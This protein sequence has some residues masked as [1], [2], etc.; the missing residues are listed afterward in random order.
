MAT[1]IW[2][3]KEGRWVLRVMKNG[4]AHKYTSKEPGIKGKKIVLAKSRASDIGINYNVTVGK[5]YER[6]LEDIRLRSSS[7][8][9]R[10]YEQYGRCYILPT[11]SKRKLVSVTANEWQN[12]LNTVRGMNGKPLAK[13]TLSNVRAIIVSFLL[14]A[15]R[16]GLE[17]PSN[18]RLQVPKNAPTKKKEILQPEH[19][20]R[21]FDDTETFI[22]EWY[23]YLFRFSVLTGLR[24]G[25]A[26]GLKW[27][28]L[29]GNVLTINRSVNY[30]NQIT[31][32][33][34][35]NARRTFA[36]GDLALTVLNEQANRTSGIK[37]DWV[38]CRPSGEM[39]VQSTTSQAWDRISAAL[40]VKTSPYSLRH[41]FISMVRNTIP[42]TVIKDVVGHSASMDTFGVY[43]HEVTDDKKREAEL[44]NLTLLKRLS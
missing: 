27:S 12:I 39:S 19:L 35:D 16:D 37:S 30:R 6:F 10:S 40:G 21:L 28:D 18:L 14:F 5:E 7:E 4:V 42:E 43:A 1:P 3:D 9:Y 26:L 11:I 8:H 41:T 17:V 25:E 34:N 2:N 33:K 29:Q 20:K 13:K 23:I 36:L 31:D 22:S 15:S 32:C 24:P 44:I 38:F